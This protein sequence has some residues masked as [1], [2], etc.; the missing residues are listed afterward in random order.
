MRDS[1]RRAGAALLAAAL[2]AAGCAAAENAAKETAEPAVPLLELP[3]LEGGSLEEIP[4]EQNSLKHSIPVKE[5]CYLYGDDSGNPTGYADPSITVNIGRGR[6]YETNY[7]YARVKIASPSQLRTLMNS[8]ITSNDTNYASTLAK[9]VN[10]V[11][12]INGDFYGGDDLWTGRKGAIM[13]QGKLQ[14]LK[15]DGRFDVLVVD[16]EGNFHILQKA[17]NEEVEAWTER[18]AN[19]FTFGP[20]LVVDGTPIYGERSSSIASEKPAQRMAICQ[21]G[22]LEYL[23]ITSEGP[24]NP[25]STGLSIYQFVDLISSMPGVQN[26]Y[27]LDGGSSSTLVFR[28]DGKNWQKIN[29]LSNP[30]I[31]PVKDIVYFASA[32]IAPEATPE[33]EVTA[34]PEV[35]PEAAPAP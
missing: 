8:S 22:P 25:G 23:L 6:I 17:K 14:R 3:A 9:R 27:N 29:A 16:R 26:A 33:P 20:A 4:V 1:I 5:S 28:M 21:T 31:R 30:K 32:W 15:C 12:A 7:I 19:I 18:A 10:A 35:T 24:Q 13:R 2:L 34:E 11:V